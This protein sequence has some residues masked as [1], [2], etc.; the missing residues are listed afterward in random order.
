MGS[1]KDVRRMNWVILVTLTMGN[2]FIVFNKSFEHKDACVNYVSNPVHS[3]TLAVEII[4]VA[5]F[6]DPIIDISCVTRRDG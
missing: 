4:A 6:N 5:G 3:D 2:P 1:I